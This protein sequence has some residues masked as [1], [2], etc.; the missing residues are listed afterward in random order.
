[1]KETQKW[2]PLWSRQ[3]DTYLHKEKDEEHT[4]EAQKKLDNAID[5]NR[6]LK[7]NL[8]TTQT[9]IAMLRAELNQM[10][11]QYDMKVNELNE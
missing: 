3:I 5:E 1:M 9:N 11:S 2:F 10:R 4:K 7:H 6:N 8:S